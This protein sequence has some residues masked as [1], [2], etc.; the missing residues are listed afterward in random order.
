VD[1]L[2]FAKLDISN[3]T[4]YNFGQALISAG[5]VVTPI[6]EIVI[7]GCTINYGGANGKYVL[8]DANTNSVN[9]TM[10]N[11]ILANSPRTGASVSNMLL[12]GTGASSALY[13]SYNNTFKLST[14]G[15]T[16]AAIGFP[17][18]SY[19]TMTTNR[20]I[21]LGWTA[22]T[23]D[24]TLPAGSELRTGGKTGG[25]IGDPRWAY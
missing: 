15:A 12:R 11:S 18:Y 4:F 14:G 21:D 17:T 3:S 7:D 16:P 19:L 23:T 22:T 8:L 5:N 13:F 9:F 6:D 24:F 10:Q 25:V 20:T 2:Q 1:K